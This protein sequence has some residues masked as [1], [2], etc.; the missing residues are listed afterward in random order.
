MEGI[1]DPVAIT[2]NNKD[3]LL[4]V[5][6]NTDKKLL[7]YEQS[8]LTKTGEIA[9]DKKPYDVLFDGKSNLFIVTAGKDDGLGKKD[10]LLLVDKDSKGI[11]K[12]FLFTKDISDTSFDGNR[13]LVCTENG[14]L[15]LAILP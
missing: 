12:E 9:F 4:A 2:V 14:D 1:K 11:L 15:Y 6:S 7:M 13:A 10:S 3:N 8:T 5:L